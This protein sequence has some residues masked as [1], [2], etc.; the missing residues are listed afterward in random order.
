MKSAIAHAEKLTQRTV[1]NV[2]VDQ[3]YK[4]HGIKGEMNVKIVG[5][6]P[7]RATRAARKWMKRRASIEPTIGHLK[8]DHRLNRNYLKGEKG[9]QANVVLAAAGYNLAKLLA[10]F[11][12]A[13]KKWTQQ[14]KKSH[15][16]VTFFT[17]SCPTNHLDFVVKRTINQYSELRYHL[18][19]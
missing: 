18:F 14:T 16:M 12:C 10:W 7:K 19:G 5:R 1:K 2:Y 13:W 9:D 6:I 11:C 8:A 15:L 17:T 4:G 3:G